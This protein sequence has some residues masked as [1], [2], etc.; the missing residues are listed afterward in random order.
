[1][2][3]M[4]QHATEADARLWAAAL[5]QH[6]SRG[7][8]NEVRRVLDGEGHAHSAGLEGPEH[9]VCREQLRDMRR[10]NRDVLQRSVICFE[11]ERRPLIE[12]RDKL[13]EELISATRDITYLLEVNQR[14]R[15]AAAELQ[16]DQSGARP[17][18]HVVAGGATKRPA[19][20]RAPSARL[21]SLGAFNEDEEDGDDGAGEL[22]MEVDRQASEIERLTAELGAATEKAK[23]LGA[24]SL[25]A[26]ALG[27]TVAG[28]K[29][30][31][32][33]ERTYTHIATL[34]KRVTVLHNQF[35][36][37]QLRQE[38][39]L[40]NTITSAKERLELRRQTI[41]QSKKKLVIVR[42][43]LA[44]RTSAWKSHAKTLGK[45]ALAMRKA[46]GG[47]G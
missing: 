19:D 29:T 38:V 39:H 36:Q 34:E 28:A 47:Q 35:E 20:F 11:Q 40:E 42:S 45:A 1:M 26:G 33:R 41:L 22:D 14:F 13:K 2:S 31:A 32:E 17:R 12:E 44:E 4:V 8:R 16:A 7:V 27:N 6:A 5:A 10:A 37:A 15:G 46:M 18:R 24:S 23:A 30:D 9:S 21:G 43:T 25:A 3:Q